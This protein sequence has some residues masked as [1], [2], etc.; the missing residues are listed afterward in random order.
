MWIQQF[1]IAEKYAVNEANIR[2]W[3]HFSADCSVR[4]HTDLEVLTGT[5]CNKAYT[6]P[7]EKDHG[8]MVIHVQEGNLIVFLSQDEENL[9]KVRVKGTSIAMLEQKCRLLPYFAK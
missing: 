9:N 5:S 8:G 7:P 3:K 1:T 6:N 4:I 2:R